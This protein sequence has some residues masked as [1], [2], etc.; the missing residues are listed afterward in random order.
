[1]SL[2]VL[3]PR[4][5]QVRKTGRDKPCPYN[6][7][8][9]ALSII[10]AYLLGSIPFGYL[11]VRW[12]KGVDVRHAGSGATG[13]TNVTRNAGKAAGIATLLL[14]ALKGYAA[15]ELARWLTGTEG[16]TWI[17]AAAAFAAIVGH[18]FPVWLGFKA[19]KGVATGLGV[20]LAIAPLATGAAAIVFLIIVVLTRYISLGSIVATA[21]LPAWAWFFQK[22]DP[23][24]QRIMVA[25]ASSA[26]L[27]IGKHHANIRRLVSGTESKF[28]GARKQ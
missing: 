19:G 21:T 25:L 10:L 8:I 27:I 17:V 13:A 1:L 12:R 6:R 4:A 9:S 26:L 18:I 3:I 5:R 22:D 14:D 24:V 20:C 15:V 2:P 23:D 7:M 16:T 11:I 28:G